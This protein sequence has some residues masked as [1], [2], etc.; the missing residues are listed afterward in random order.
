MAITWETKIEVEDVPSKR[1]AIT[2][3]RTDDAIP[4]SPVVCTYG[5][6]HTILK[7][8]GGETLAQMR[9]RIAAEIFARYTAE[10]AHEANVADVVSTYESALASALNGLEI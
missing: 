4:E 1:V 2:A 10:V 6:F 5:P 7:P 9:D 3:T 8:I